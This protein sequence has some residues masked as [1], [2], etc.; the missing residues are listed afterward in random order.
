MFTFRKF[1]FVLGT[2][3]ALLLVI[4]CGQKTSGHKNYLD[5]STRS[6]NTHHFGDLKTMNP[7]DGDDDGDGG[8]SNDDGANNDDGNPDEIRDEMTGVQQAAVITGKA[9]F[10]VMKM[11]KAGITET[12]VAQKIDE[13][14]GQNSARDCFGS[15]VG[16][17][18]NSTDLH[19]SPGN[20]QLKNGEVVVVDIGAT[21][22]SYCSDV[23]RTYPVNGKFTPRQREIYQLV[24]DAQ[25]AAVAYGKPGKTSLSDLDRFVR[26]FFRKSSITADGQTMDHFFSHGLGHFVG[27]VVHDSGDTSSP[28]RENDPFTLE[29]GLYIESEEIGVRIEDDFI[30]TKDGIKNLVPETPSDV[31]TI[32]RLINED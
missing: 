5:S 3:C 19:H 8:E 13:V 18:P 27:R 26:E 9:H 17:G 10:T 4:G 21:F 31:D 16:T 32:E 15:I 23:T 30:M 7:D 25:K 20:I 12:G 11:L 28:L 2:F 14:Y 6:A 1:L 24:L 29:P 22:N